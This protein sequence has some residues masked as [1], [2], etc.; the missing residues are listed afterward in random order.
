MKALLFLCLCLV[1]P[2]KLQLDET[3]RGTCKSC[4]AP[5]E[6][7]DINSHPV[8]TK[9]CPDI[10]GCDDC[11]DRDIIQFSFK[12]SYGVFPD[13]VNLTNSSTLTTKSSFLNGL[14]KGYCRLC[15]T[16]S[17]ETTTTGAKVELPIIPINSDDQCLP[18]ATGF[19]CGFC[20]EH[21]GFYHSRRGHCV[22]SC[23]NLSLNWF[24]FI[25]GEFLPAT[26]LF[27]IID[28]TD[29][30]LVIGGLN[31]AI[32]FAQM[33]ITTMNIFDDGF[34]P[35]SNITDNAHTSY[36]LKFPYRFLYGV[37]NLEFF[38]PLL[39]DICLYRG[40]HFI[41][42]AIIEYCIA[43]FPLIL[44]FIRYSF[45]KIKET[46]FHKFNKHRNAILN[47]K[48]HNLF[49]LVMVLSYTKLALTSSWI[50]APIEILNAQTG[51]IV[52]FVS[53]F[54]P[55]ISYYEPI[56]LVFLVIAFVV[57]ALLI[58][59]PLV[60]LF[61]RY[62]LQM[63]SNNFLDI[64]LKPI[65]NS[66]K[67]KCDV[68]DCP[69]CSSSGRSRYSCINFHDNRWVASF[70]F[71]LRLVSLTIYA[72]PFV[73]TL[74]NYIL[75]QV[76]CIVGAMCVLFVQPYRQV[77]SN[78][79][80][81]FLLLLLAFINTLSIYQYYLTV[82][83]FQLSVFVFVLQYIMIFIPAIGI[84]TYVSYVILQGIHKFV[85]TRTNKKNYE[86]IDFSTEQH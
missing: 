52:Q 35:L 84:A 86:T 16:L 7:Y 31:S 83:G 18:N 81:V 73:D 75:Q 12:R 47:D 23:D 33:I 70:Y 9:C 63:E 59:L 60:L 19:M 26:I 36:S 41:Y 58:F 22:Q 45:K 38:S 30:A 34:I 44:L 40:K 4:H 54:D 11:V 14:V 20:N 68:A 24:L 3:E 79:I 13:V 32:F 53:L 10:P 8:C 6:C 1:L 50:I 76:I 5:D 77:L 67:S 17:L 56:N 51:E 71:I 48:E 62:R 43:L 72:I 46:Y 66:F 39:D 82:R 29:I 42:Y 25:L 15:S 64:M 69:K 21:E 85:V 2:V 37:W 28:I 65:Q 57:Y 80:D 78:R 49:A 61:M 55:T 27:V 74:V